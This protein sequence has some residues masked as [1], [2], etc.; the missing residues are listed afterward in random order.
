[1]TDPINLTQLRDQ[2]TD[3]MNRW[4]EVDPKGLGH[5]RLSPNCSP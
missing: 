2:A 1:M 4:P 3:R 5:Q